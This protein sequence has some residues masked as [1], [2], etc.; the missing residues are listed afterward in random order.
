MNRT[1]TSLAVLGAVLGL[2]GCTAEVA[3]GPN[4]PAASVPGGSGAGGSSTTVPDPQPEG[5][6][7]GTHVIHR[8]TRTEYANT[9]RDLLGTS[10]MSLES[11]PPDTGGEG[12]SKTSLSQ[13]SSTNT[14]QAYEAASNEVIETVFKDPALK[15]QLVTCD[16]A[17]GT[18][19]VRST[20]EAF[21]PKAWRRP[22]EAAEVD[23]LLVLADTEAQAGGSAEEQLKLTL[24]AALTSVKFLYLLEKDPNPADT[25]PH[26]LSD[27]ELASRLSYFLWS[28]MPDTDL[29][30]L[31]AQGKLQ[32][33]T[34]LAQQVTRMLADP[35][36]GAAMTNVFAAEWV[37]LQVIP[38]KQ[39]DRT[40]FPMVDDA[41]KQSMIQQTTTFFQDLLT[42]G[43]P[44]SNLVASDYTFVDAGLASLY[45][46]PAPQGPGFVKTSLT[47]TT[48]I[49]GI[50][51][52]S[53]I[54]MQFA[55][56]VRSSAVKRGA[57]VLE[58][59]LCA[60]APPPPPD[61]AAASAAQEMDPEFQAKVAQQ[62]WRE[63]LAEHREPSS[64]A[65][66]HNMIDPIGLAL[67][68]YDA[69]GQY[70]T[71]DVGKVIDA[72]GELVPGDTSTAFTDAFGMTALL[73]KDDRVASCIA[74]KLLTFA[75]TRSPTTSEINYVSALTAG[76]SD[77]LGNVITKVVTGNPFRYRVGAG[78]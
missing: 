2:V 7:I 71:M 58:S 38:E 62:T 67:E 54:L 51:G 49:G 63:R 24:R 23:R 39:P 35:I 9:I 13:A 3:S 77:A 8:L 53:S 17:T 30:S 28:S 44:V 32:D 14:L 69:V 25:T 16:L 50:L 11:L 20:L 40:L 75:L 19:C 43:A 70:R 60:P 12:F 65:V 26:K 76:N 47:G 6:V 66:C 4:S 55:S 10:L 36:K 33:D 68:N 22:V 78:L 45:G 31:A 52:Q 27:Y 57:W 64:C 1:T 29:M 21:L 41:L 74:Q 59:V 46:L 18:A 34:V 56:Q 61:V 15:G 42:S 48:R 73:A 5:L 72:S 37:H